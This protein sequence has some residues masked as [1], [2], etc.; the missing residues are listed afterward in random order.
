V[1]ERSLKFVAEAC[2][3]EIRRG[4]DESRVKN[5]CTDSRQAK[6]GD[7]FFAIRGEKFDGHEFL[8]EVGARGVA[9][10]V[11]EKGKIPMPL[12]DCG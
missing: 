8:A 12:P 3:A 7:L 11:V 2:A 6:P 5:I 1:E 4:P 10:V 9:A